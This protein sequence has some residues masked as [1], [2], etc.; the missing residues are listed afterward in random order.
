MKATLT[1]AM[2]ENVTCWNLECDG[3]AVGKIKLNETSG[4]YHA[5]IDAMSF[6]GGGLYQ[7][8]G[9]TPEL[10]IRQLL[11]KHE[12]YAIA[13]LRRIEQLRELLLSGEE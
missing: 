4:N 2:P 3:K 12:K 8:H 11:E 6:E 1:P 13:Q 5:I 9:I 10:A 7:G